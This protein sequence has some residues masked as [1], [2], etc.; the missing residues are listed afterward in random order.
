MAARVLMIRGHSNSWERK[1]KNKCEASRHDKVGKSSLESDNTLLEAQP[2][3]ATTAD[4]VKLDCYSS[5]GKNPPNLKKVYKSTAGCSDGYSLVDCNSFIDK[6]M[7][8]CYPNWENYGVSHGGY[9]QQNKMGEVQCVAEGSWMYIT[10]Q[11]R[12]CKLA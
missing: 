6:G 9:L 10:A 7:D 5:N 3:C 2:L 8:Q 4:S 1:K 12:C 11:A